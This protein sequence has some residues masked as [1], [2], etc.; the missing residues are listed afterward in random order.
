VNVL[1]TGATGFVGGHL[2]DRLLER[3]DAVT[4]LV[5]SAPRAE[6]LA[7]RGVRLVV[8]DLANRDALADAVHDQQLIYHVAALLGA[9]TEAALVAANRDGTANVARAADAETVPP[10][11]VLVSSMAA[12]GPAERGVPKRAAGDDHPVTGYGRSKLA[13]EQAL[14]QFPL[15]WIVLRPSVVY[16]PRDRDS[17]L[18]L[19]KLVKCGLAPTFGDGSM[20]TSF[21]EVHDLVEAMIIAGDS[22]LSRQVFY[23]NHPEIVTQSQLMQRIAQTLGRST[24][25]LPIPEWAARMALAMT[26]AWSDLTHQKSI[27]H[28]DKIHEFYQPAWTADPSVFMAATGWRPQ[29]P[30]SRGLAETVTWYRQAGWI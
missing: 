13:A 4:A 14:A 11:V 9:G 29:Y 7:R 28:S 12:G 2:V 5:R 16:G 15:D 17:F 6:S 24:I 30:L 20:E 10:R 22:A 19:V 27:L 25:S 26:G 18:P 21:L 23:V 1:V 3:G 8:G